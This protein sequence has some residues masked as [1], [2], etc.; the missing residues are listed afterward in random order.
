[1]RVFW[2]TGHSLELLGSGWRKKLKKWKKRETTVELTSGPRWSFRILTFLWSAVPR[3]SGRNQTS[4]LRKSTTFT[5]ELEKLLLFVFSFFFSLIFC[6]LKRFLLLDFSVFF[7]FFYRFTVKMMNHKQLFLH[8]RATLNLL[9]DNFMRKI[10][11]F[12][13][14]FSKV[15]I[16]F[17]PVFVSWNCKLCQNIFLFKNSGLNVK[18]ISA[19]LKWCYV[20]NW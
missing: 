14:I 13:F 18:I 3:P 6:A 9:L 5:T 1:M 7:V 17:V 15:I 16:N 19:F 8:V 20:T 4:V 2:I 10:I 11:T 12:L